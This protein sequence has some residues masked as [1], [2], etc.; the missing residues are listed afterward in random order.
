MENGNNI[1]GKINLTREQ[2]YNTFKVDEELAIEA[3][4][5]VSRAVPGCVNFVCE[6]YGKRVH[7]EKLERAD[8][9]DALP[10]SRREEK[11]CPYCPISARQTPGGSSWH[12]GTV[13]RRAAG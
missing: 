10:F 6:T 13:D 1:A 8:L 11:D 12:S 5:Q 3:R 2:E 9:R 4:V 7:T